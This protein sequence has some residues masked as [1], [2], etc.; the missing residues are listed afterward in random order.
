MDL[1]KIVK[2]KGFSFENKFN[3]LILIMKKILLIL[4]ILVFMAC[5][6][7]SNVPKDIQWEITKENPNDNLSKNN[8]EVH[9]NKKVDQ[10]VL[11]EIAMEIREDRTQYDR[12]WIFYHIPNMTEGMA[13]ATTHF[14]PNLEINII[15]STENQDVKTS[16][17]TDIEGEV[18][19]KWRS[20]KSLMGA[21]LILFKNSFQKKIMII[22][23][24]DGSKMESEIVESNV[25]GKVKYQD[26]NENG[27][28]YILESNGNLGLYVKNGKFDEAIKIE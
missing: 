8:I 2:M 11:Q 6:K 1:R 25:N 26:D 10:K 28:Y 4:A 9:L 7:K 23:F 15:G 21:T 19:N 27:E 18:L 13:W 22:K 14:T 5:E 24:K 12:L 20:E 17:T 16:K 3:Q